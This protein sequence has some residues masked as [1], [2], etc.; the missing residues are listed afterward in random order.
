M[1][2]EEG[3]GSPLV[4]EDIPLLKYESEIFIKTGAWKSI[5]ELERNLTLDELFLIYRASSNEVSM[6]MKIAA[7]AQGADVD[8]N[9]DWYDPEPEKVLDA[10]ALTS[11]PFGIGYS[12]E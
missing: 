4:W 5:E 9:D 10:S 1:T 12:V 11:L 8:F 3:E 2:N 6:Q 7:A